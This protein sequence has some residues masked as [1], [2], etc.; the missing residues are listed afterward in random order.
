MRWILGTIAL[1][2]L[3]LALRLNLL[4]YAMYVLLGVLALTRFFTRAWVNA[5][6][7]R[8][9]GG[10]DVFEIGAEV[11]VKV[12]VQDTGALSVPWLLLEDA[13]S[14]E[15][16]TQTPPRIKAQG[17]RLVLTRLLPG[18]TH[19]LAYKLQFLMRGYYQI[20][21]LLAETGDVFG[22]HRRF[23]VITEPNFAL[24]L[25]K[26]LPL[27]GYNL[28]SRRPIGEIRLAHRLFEDP[29]RIAG[30]RPY[31]HGD[32][33]NRIHWRASARTGQWQSRQ[34]ESS[35]VAGATFL[36]D[37]HARSFSGPTATAS[38]ELAIVTVASLA[39][40][41]YLMGQQMGFI[42]NGRDAAD[43]IR[44]EGW[45]AEFLTRKDAIRRAGNP[46]ENTR[47][48][49]VI[50][51]PARGEDQ[52]NAILTTMARLEHTD[53]LD[54]AAAARDAAARISRD[55]T[56]VAVLGSVTLDIAAALGD[57]ARRGLP[58]TA[59]VVSLNMDA[60]PDWAKPPE[61]AEMLL[62]QGIDFRVVNSEESISNLCAEA[63]VR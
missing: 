19:V 22:L 55:T 13:L 50:I 37:F 34:C 43:R 61:W 45:R 7:A 3:G 21:P 49:P 18:H 20:G 25:P 36:L 38:A 62:A 24:V 28:S 5:I 32:P 26:V 31:Q 16:L 52:F 12:A 54:L 23:R 6:D 44:E 51:K 2:A 15:A 33:L 1:L 10:D 40:A 11:D 53:G 29:T 17:G 39:N 35:C 57:I 59:I 41:V 14:R 47:L 4:I 30:V 42:S 46:K 9:F 8:R 63:I 48:V 58:V 60:V 56:V 27:Q